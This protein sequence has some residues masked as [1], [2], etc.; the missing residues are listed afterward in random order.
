MPADLGL[1]NHPN[2]D[3]FSMQDGRCEYRF[4]GMAD[5]VPKVNPI[6]QTC[7]TLVY[8]DDVRLHT[9]GSGDDG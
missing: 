4:D 5:G 2:R 3:A 8:G 7:F 1:E 9:D 6:S